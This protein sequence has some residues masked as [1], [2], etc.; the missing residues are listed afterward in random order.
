[1]SLSI[2]INCFP[3]A[4]SDLVANEAEPDESADEAATGKFPEICV[5]QMFSATDCAAKEKVSVFEPTSKYTPAT[6]SLDFMHGPLQYD[7]VR[8]IGSEERALQK[9]G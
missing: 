9:K 5:D 1:M 6:N 8:K 4:T 3:Q 7:E 2:Q